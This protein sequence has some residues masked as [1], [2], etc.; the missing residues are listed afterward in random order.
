MH[1]SC[2]YNKC[3]FWC[4][5]Q[6]TGAGERSVRPNINNWAPGNAMISEGTEGKWHLGESWHDH[7]WF[8]WW[9]CFLGVDCGYRGMHAWVIVFRDWAEQGT[10][11]LILRDGLCIKAVWLKR[12]IPETAP[13]HSQDTRGHCNITKPA[14]QYKALKRFIFN[15]FLNI[16][17]LNLAWLKLSTLFMN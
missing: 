8:M 11:H 14:D 17:N 9:M 3:S 13:V 1:P 4:E 5:V 12:D 15:C 7:H 10:Q 6:T 16:L 2:R